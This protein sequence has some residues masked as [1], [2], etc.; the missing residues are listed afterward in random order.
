VQIPPWEEVAINLIGP[1]KVKVD[2]QL[3][4]FNA[5]TYTDTALNLVKLIH[6]D[7]KTADHIRDKFTQSGFY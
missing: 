6:V 1:W 5:F 4:E 2:G 3:V 7:N